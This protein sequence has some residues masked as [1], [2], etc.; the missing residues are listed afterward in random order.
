MCCKKQNK[1]ITIIKY[2]INNKI[3]KVNNII[4]NNNACEI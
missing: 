2:K 4:L 1:N 3:Y